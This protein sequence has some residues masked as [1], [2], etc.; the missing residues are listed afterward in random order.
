MRQPPHG[1]SLRAAVRGGADQRKPLERL[2]RYIVRPTIA[3]ERLKRNRAEDVV[4]QLKSFYHRATHAS[5]D[6]VKTLLLLAYVERH[7]DKGAKRAQ[8]CTRSGISVVVKRG[9]SLAAVHLPSV[10]FQT[11]L[12]A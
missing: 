1:F 9:T 7:I 11:A 5:L 2:C 10:G 8:R 6:G 4:L 12:T 3:N